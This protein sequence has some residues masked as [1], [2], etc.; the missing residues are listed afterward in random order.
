MSFSAETAAL[1]NERYGDCVK[2]F[3]RA[4]T[5]LEKATRG[6]I[7]SFIELADAGRPYLTGL[8]TFVVSEREG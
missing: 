3:R 8:G 4:G 5:E 1:V 7:G 6:I 2:D